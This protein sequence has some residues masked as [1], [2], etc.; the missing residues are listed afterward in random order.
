VFPQNPLTKEDLPHEA[1]YPVA[2]EPE[3]GETDKIP[4][5]IR[6]DGVESEPDGYTVH[7]KVNGTYEGEPVS[8]AEGE[9]VDTKGNVWRVGG[10]VPVPFDA[11]QGQEVEIEATVDLPEGGTSQW[12]E[13]SQLG[14]PGLRYHSTLEIEGGQDP[15]VRTQSTVEAEFDLSVDADHER[16]TGEDVLKYVDYMIEVSSRCSVSATT[17]DGR[18]QVLDG[19]LSWMEDQGLVV[20]QL[21]LFIS[22]EISETNILTCPEGTTTSPSVFYFSGFYG[23]HGGELCGAENEL[24][25]SAGGVVVRNWSPGSGGVLARKEYQRSCTMEGVTFTEDTT[26]ELVDPL[27]GG[28]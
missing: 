20:D 11:R 25:Q 19:K 8:L 2:G 12:S 10:E 22:P 18:L 21:V 3:D 9:A 16:V 6:V 7:V 4:F 5:L 14:N 27:A 24:D 23:F 17:M 26:L 13:S 1:P 15:I 28:G